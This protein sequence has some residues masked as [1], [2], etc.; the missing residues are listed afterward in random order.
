M[1]DLPAK[2]PLRPLELPPALAEIEQVQA[3]LAD[4]PPRHA[5]FV[6][7]FYS[8]GRNAAEAAR[9]AGFSSKGANSKSTGWK[10]LHRRPKIVAAVRKIDGHL[11]RRFAYSSVKSVTFSLYDNRVALA[12]EQADQYYALLHRQPKAA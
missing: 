3:I 4:L 8:N 6:A 9:Y 5:S 2:L 10:L 7:R 1:A 12:R 11:S